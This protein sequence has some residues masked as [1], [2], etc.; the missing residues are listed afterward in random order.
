MKTKQTPKL[1]VVKG[2]YTADYILKNP[3]SSG[4]K[5]PA[6]WQAAVEEYFRREKFSFDKKDMKKPLVGVN[7]A[8]ITRIMGTLLGK[9]NPPRPK[10]NKRRVS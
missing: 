5:Y 6:V 8:E 4:K 10:S 9:R 3:S 1:S 7:F 2:V